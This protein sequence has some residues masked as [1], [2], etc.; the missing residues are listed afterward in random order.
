MSIV[1]IVAKERRSRNFARTGEKSDPI[2]GRYL[3]TGA[4]FERTIAIYAG[5]GAT[6]DATVVTRDIDTGE[7]G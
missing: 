2:D 5:T 1:R 4:S 7:R 3:V 6:S